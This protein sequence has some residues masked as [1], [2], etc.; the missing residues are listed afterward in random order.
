MDGTTVD[1]LA[2]ENGLDPNGLLPAG[3]HLSISGAS[4]AGG[5]VSSAATSG[6]S[7]GY[8]VQPGD[9]LSGIAA[10]NGVTVHQLAAENGLDP[11]GILLAGAHLSI[12]GRDGDEL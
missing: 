12:S 1:Q 2:A 8:V 5:S 11:S 3:A 7:G 10:A 4:S 9:T 6:A